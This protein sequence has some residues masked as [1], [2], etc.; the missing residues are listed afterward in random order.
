MS[1]DSHAPSP[2]TQP[3]PASVVSPAPPRQDRPRRPHRPRSA[4]P[5]PRPP[6]AGAPRSGPQHLYRPQRQ[7]QFVQLGPV[8]LEPQQPGDRNLTLII[9]LVVGLLILVG[10]GVLLYVGFI[11]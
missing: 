10:A 4:P 2:T 11:A 3:D 7:E 1:Y 8:A 5:R 6:G 9:A